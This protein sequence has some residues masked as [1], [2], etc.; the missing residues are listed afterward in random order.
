M[1]R[2]R[3]HG[4]LRGSFLLRPP[5]RRAAARLGGGL[6]RAASLRQYSQ[7]FDAQ[8]GNAT[9]LPYSDPTFSCA[10]SNAARDSSLA[11]PTRAA[12]SAQP[13]WTFV[14]SPPIPFRVA[15]GPFSSKCRTWRGD[16]FRKRPIPRGSISC[17]PGDT[18]PGTQS[19]AGFAGS[20]DAAC[21]GGFPRT[22]TY[23]LPL[24]ELQV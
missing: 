9:R 20:A 3:N 7:Q 19:L 8:C 21:L 17:A 15:G 12:K 22:E 5:A 18:V 16:Y 14:S 4:V 24:D 13:P 6:L 11:P 23:V 1:I 10:K 2:A